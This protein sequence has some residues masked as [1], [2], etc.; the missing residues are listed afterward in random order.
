MS[1]I[2]LLLYSKPVSHNL[3]PPPPVSPSK[4][5]RVPKFPVTP[6]L[7]QLVPPHTSSNSNAMLN[8]P[9]SNRA[10]PPL[11]PTCGKAAPTVLLLVGNLNGVNLVML[12][13]PLSPT[14]STGKK[15]CVCVCA[16]YFFLRVLCLFLFLCYLLVCYLLV[17]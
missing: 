7:V 11:E 8:N 14:D 5:P 3:H 2:L 17:C 9:A 1:K 15:F 6:F 13:T 12:S 10:Q 4:T 16:R